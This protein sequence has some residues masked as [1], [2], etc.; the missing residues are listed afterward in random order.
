MKFH[1]P[2]KIGNGYKTLYEWFWDILD[3]QDMWDMEIIWT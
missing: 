1:E 2:S 3:W